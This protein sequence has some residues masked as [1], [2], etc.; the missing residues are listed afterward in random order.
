[1]YDLEVAATRRFAAMSTAQKRVYLKA[2]PASRLAIAADMPEQTDDFG[3]ETTP[4]KKIKGGKDIDIGDTTAK[5]PSKGGGGD[6]IDL[7]RKEGIV[8]EGVASVESQTRLVR[9][10]RAEASAAQIFKSMSS[11]ER[12]MYLKANRVSRFAPK[13]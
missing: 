9:M 11:V 12:V 1:M 6:D 5:D 13:K 10:A 7:G 8:T 4:A 2:H 3:Q